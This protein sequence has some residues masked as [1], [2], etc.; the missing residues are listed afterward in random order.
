MTCRHCGEENTATARFCAQCGHAL[1]RACSTSG[2]HVRP[3]QRFCGLAGFTP[4]SEARD[5]ERVRELVSRNFEV[6]RSTAFGA[7]LTA[8]RELGSPYHLAIGLLDYAEHLQ[9]IGAPGVELPATEAAAIAAR[10]GARPL[11]DRAQRLTASLTEAAHQGRL[12]AVPDV[13]GRQPR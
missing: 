11:V 6:G 1:T 5:P 7:A 10:L 13:R 9:A 3:G 8:F 2:A 4:L 12:H